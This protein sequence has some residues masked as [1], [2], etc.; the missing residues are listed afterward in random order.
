MDAW[1]KTG[2]E[3]EKDGQQAPEQKHIFRAGGTK[4]GKPG[5]DKVSPILTVQLLFCL[6]V[7]AFVLVM[8]FASPGFFAQMGE[9]YEKML[10]EGVSLTSSGELF[11]FASAGVESLQEK[12]RRAVEQLGA[13]EP[14]SALGQGGQYEVTHAG[15]LKTVTLASYVL[16][17]RP[18]MPV[19]GTLTSSFGYRTHPITGK[20]DFHTGVDLAAPQGTPVAAAWTGVVAETGFNDINGNYVK[21]IHSGNVCT[22][23]N[24]LSAISVQTGQRLRRGE[25]VGL[26]GSTGISTGPHLHFELLIDGVRVDPA[27]ALGL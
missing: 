5:E 8:R 2:E 21:M 4:A 14:D 15:Y 17:D 25:V 12:L 27:P 3:A 7:V 18:G 23:Y 24:H 9:R 11:R 26:V 19:E 22:T 16:S 10:T 20:T 6:C 1:V 13:K